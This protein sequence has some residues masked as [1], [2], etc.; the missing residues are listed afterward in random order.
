MSTKWNKSQTVVKIQNQIVRIFQGYLPGTF[1]V[2][3]RGLLEL[4]D[5]ATEIKTK[6]D[7]YQRI[8]EMDYAELFMFNHRF[9]KFIGDNM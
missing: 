7:L 4:W 1:G 3:C 5:I 2:P 6:L 9:N 8:H